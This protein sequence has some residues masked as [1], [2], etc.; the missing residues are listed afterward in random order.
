MGPLGHVYLQ[1]SIPPSR[2]AALAD[3]LVHQARIPLVLYTN[4]DKTTAVNRR[5]RFDLWENRR[6]VLGGDHPYLDQ[7]AADLERV[8][9]HS[10]AGDWIISGWAPNAQPLTF[11]VENGAHGG[12]GSQETEAFILL[13]QSNGSNTAVLRPLDLRRYVFDLL[14][15]EPN[16]NSDRSQAP[17]K[18][19]PG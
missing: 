2:K 4:G 3:K 18:R 13:P 7:T 8:C 10:N 14:A 1:R 11:A 16:R 5:G 6:Q 12:P 19:F 17:E 15:A 9:R